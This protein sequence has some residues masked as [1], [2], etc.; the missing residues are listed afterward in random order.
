MSLFEKIKKLYALNHEDDFAYSEAEITYFEELYDFKLPKLLKEYYLSLG[1][2]V[3]LNRNQIRF[4]RPRRLWVTED[5]FLVFAEKQG[6]AVWA[7]NLAE[8][9]KE[10]PPIFRAPDG[11]MDRVL[12]QEENLLLDQFLYAGAMING[13]NGALPFRAFSMNEFDDLTA[14]TLSLIESEWTEVT[15]NEPFQNSR[16]FT[17]QDEDAV[18]IEYDKENNP[19]SISIGTSYS[20]RFQHLLSILP[21]NWTSIAN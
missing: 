15:R 21:I 1:N 16:I 7:F 8:R 2:H 11:E 5:N 10:K 3:A 20:N 12:W 4:Y 13:V 19:L 9:E 14:E 6:E 17:Y 18:V